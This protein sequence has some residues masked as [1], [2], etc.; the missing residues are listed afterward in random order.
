MLRVQVFAFF[1]GSQ[2]RYAMI[3]KNHSPVLIFEIGLKMGRFVRSK[4]YEN[5]TKQ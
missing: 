4:T 3:L 1:K 5:E 2:A